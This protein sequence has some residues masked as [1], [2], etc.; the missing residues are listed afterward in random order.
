MDILLDLD[1]EV[2]IEAKGLDV[3]IPF[4]NFTLHGII[5]NTPLGL[6]ETWPDTVGQDWRGWGFRSREMFT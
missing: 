5:S 2:E 6:G 1:V 3:E 4:E